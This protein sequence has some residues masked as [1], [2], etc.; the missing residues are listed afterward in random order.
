MRGLEHALAWCE[1]V[2][3][4]AANACLIAM[5]AL[6]ALNIAVRAVLD[7]SL[8]W[9]WPWTLVLFVWMTFLGFF[10]IYRRS[11]D[12]TVDYFVKLAGNWAMLATRLMAN[13]IIIG[14]MVLILWQAPLVIENQVGEIELT[15]IERWSLSLPLFASSILLVLHSLMDIVLALQGV[16]E[17]RHEMAGIDA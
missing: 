16:P 12:I 7:T 6:N 11:K 5:L 4:I 8:I 14:L 15:G 1:R 17:P 9:V 13:V 10:V 2:F 3:H